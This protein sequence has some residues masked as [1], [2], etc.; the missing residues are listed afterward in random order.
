MTI[1]VC[2]VSVCISVTGVVLI[3]QSLIVVSELPE[4][5]IDPSGEKATDQT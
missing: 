1:E 4:A 5:R 2:L 3:F